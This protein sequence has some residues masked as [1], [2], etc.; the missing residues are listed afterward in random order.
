MAISGLVI[1]Y[2]EEKNIGKCIDALFE[3]CD[4]VIIVDS[5]SADNTVKIA[6]EKGAKVLSQKFLAMDHNARTD[7]LFAKTIGF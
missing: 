6:E 3:V 5:L 1:T 2:N 4:E 7:Y